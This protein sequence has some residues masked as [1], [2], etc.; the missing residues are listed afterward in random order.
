MQDFN[1]SV[2]DLL[3]RPGEYRDVIVERPVTDVETPL[4]RLQSSP[5]RAELRAESVVEGI[6]VTGHATGTAILSCARCLESFEAPLDLD[7]CEL[8]VAPGGEA[9]DP[10]AYTVTGLELDLEPMMRDAIALSLPFKPVCSESCRGMCA[11]CGADLNQGACEC[12]DDDVDPRWA[13]LASLRAQLSDEGRSGPVRP[14]DGRS[15]PVR[16]AGA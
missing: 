11:R 15:G 14:E 7:L 16:P 1:L 13:A 4:A 9:A 10:D 8:F 3:G 2:V 5:V 6:L 12:V